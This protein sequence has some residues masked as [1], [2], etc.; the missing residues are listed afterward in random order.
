[1]DKLTL[2]NNLENDRIFVDYFN[3]FLCSEGFNQHVCWSINSFKLFTSRQISTSKSS[4]SSNTSKS[5]QSSGERVL[6]ASRGSSRRERRNQQQQIFSW[7][8]ENRLP[9]FLNSH[10]FRLYKF[11]NHLRPKLSQNSCKRNS[12]VEKNLNHPKRYHSSTTTRTSFPQIETSINRAQSLPLITK[13]NKLHGENVVERSRDSNDGRTSSVLEFYNDDEKQDKSEA[14]EEDSQIIH[15]DEEKRRVEFLDFLRSVETSEHLLELWFLVEEYFDQDI[16]PTSKIKRNQIVKYM[17]EH[18]ASYLTEDAKIFLNLTSKENTEAFGEYFAQTQ[19]DIMERIQNY[20]L[21]RFTLHLQVTKRPFS[22]PKRKQLDHKWF[23]AEFNLV[24]SLSVLPE[25]ERND[26][27]KH[28][29]E[30]EDIPNERLE[31]EQQSPASSQRISL[32]KALECEKD[33]GFPFKSWIG[34][35]RPSECW[36]VEFILALKELVQNTELFKDRLLKLCDT[37]KFY[38]KYCHQ[39]SEISSLETSRIYRKL[40]KTE[41]ISTEFLL[42]TFNGLQEQALSR[43]ENTWQEFQQQ[44]IFVIRLESAPKVILNE[45]P[46]EDETV[47]EE[48]EI[49]SKQNKRTSSSKRQVG[50]RWVPRLPGSS[51][52]ERRTRL[53]TAITMAERCSAIRNHGILTSHSRRYMHAEKMTLAQQKRR[54]GT[55]DEEESEE[56]YEEMVDSSESENEEEDFLDHIDDKEVMSSF[57][58]FVQEHEGKGLMNELLMYLEI[59]NYFSLFGASKMAQRESNSIAIFKTFFETTSRKSIDLPKVL[60]STVTKERPTSSLLREAQQFVLPQ[61]TSSFDSYIKYMNH[62]NRSDSK[63]EAGPKESRSEQK[64]EVADQRWQEALLANKFVADLKKKTFKEGTTSS[65][66]RREHHQQFL[67]TVS[68]LSSKKNQTL[69]SKFHRYLVRCEDMGFPRAG[70]NLLFFIEVIKYKEVFLYMDEESSSR[71]AEVIVD[72]FLDSVSPPWL[73]VDVSPEVASRISQ[74]VQHTFR[75][76]I[77]IHLFDEASNMILKELLPFWTLFIKTHLKNKEKSACSV[78]EK[79]KVH[80]EDQSPFQPIIVKH[81]EAQEMCENNFLSFSLFNGYSWKD[82]TARRRKN[83]SILLNKLPLME[84]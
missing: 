37:W 38:Q 61:L 74:K 26:V 64:D 9:Y 44:D 54:P 59:E 71:K 39:N 57:K 15:F 43:L 78:V 47:N 14:N 52:S 40:K 46:L 68:N 17:Q 76:F 23:F 49:F 31:I 32:K 33:C 19:H 45:G 29:F 22:T 8:H 69:I 56:D 2:K 5:S 83:P 73:Q 30:I 36:S 81:E 82:G 21:K 6:T 24:Q 62:F 60:V 10:Y 27:I 16:S 58:S 25:E 51:K 1:M 42:E 48:E 41:I 79:K 20:W 13:N 11:F 77:D 72:V 80:W 4:R 35:F 84:N 75:R 63:N 28:N 3:R 12:P 66:K 53:M 67:K 18:F 50:N 34:K 55:K 7:I 65:T 70:K